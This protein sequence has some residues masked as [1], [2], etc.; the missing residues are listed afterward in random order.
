MIAPKLASGKCAN[1]KNVIFLVSFLRKTRPLRN[2]S[3]PSNSNLVDINENIID[4]TNTIN[5]KFNTV[6]TG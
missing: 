2:Q 1:H 5:L 4:D 3:P 6:K